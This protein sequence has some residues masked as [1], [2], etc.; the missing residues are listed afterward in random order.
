MGKVKHSL[1]AKQLKDI[2]RRELTIEQIKEEFEM[3]SATF[4]KILKKY[5]MFINFEKEALVKEI[6][7]H[8]SRVSK[9]QFIRDTGLDGARINAFPHGLQLRYKPLVRLLNFYEVKYA[10]D[11]LP[12]KDRNGVFFTTEITVDIN[13][14]EASEAKRKLTKKRTVESTTNYDILYLKENLKIIESHRSSLEEMLNSKRIGAEVISQ[15]LSKFD[16]AVREATL[17]G[18]HSHKTGKGEAIEKML[19]RKIHES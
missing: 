12:V 19:Y 16:M 13:P 6:K 2:I 9:N 10:V 11:F 5:D 17:F 15:V 18:L 3:E 4:Y 7:E 8:Y 14:F 1:S